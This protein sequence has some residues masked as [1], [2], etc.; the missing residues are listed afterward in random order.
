MKNQLLNKQQKLNMPYPVKAVGGIDVQVKEVDLDKRTVIFIA[1]TLYYM[2]R[3]YDI[4]IDGV[5][6]RSIADRGPNS[7][8]I[9]KIK[10]LADHIMRTDKMIGKPKLIEETTYEGNKVILF[11]STIS[12][13]PSGDEHLIKYQDGTYDNHSIGFR[14][15]DLAFASKDSTDEDQ[16]NRYFE[17]ISQIINRQEAEDLGFFWVVKEIELFEASVVAFG[18]NSL[19]PVIG[20]K[21]AD[22]NT[23]QFELYS[24]INSINDQLKSGVNKEDKQFFKNIELQFA[25]VKQ[26]MSEI[27]T[28][29]YDSPKKEVLEDTKQKVISPTADN[30]NDIKIVNEDEAKTYLDFLGEEL[31][32]L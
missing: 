5:A 19:T 9:A 3:D 7:Q 14:Y 20:V 1:N 8:A 23:I 6:K 10:H 31:D 17:Y 15:I 2:D 26:I 16:R 30:G 4:L 21:N 24:R 27:V 29:K 25:Q 32:K 18:S 11:E 12:E 28:S 13:G 22:L